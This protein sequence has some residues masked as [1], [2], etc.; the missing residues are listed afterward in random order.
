MIDRDRALA[1]AAGEERAL[2]AGDRGPLAGVPV[3]CFHLHRRR[4]R[5]PYPDCG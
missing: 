1:A 3:D 2:L 5:G 4:L